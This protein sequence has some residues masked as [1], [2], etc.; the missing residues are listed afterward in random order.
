MRKKIWLNIDDIILVALRDYGNIHDIINKYSDDN[1]L[2]LKDNNLIP[3][4]DNSNKNEKLVD[5][6]DIDNKDEDDK[7][8]EYINYNDVLDI[9]SDNES[10]ND[11][12]REINAI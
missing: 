10:E 3:W 6:I 9:I 12:D 8:K 1:I 4:S 5:F 11:S 2:Y 7:N